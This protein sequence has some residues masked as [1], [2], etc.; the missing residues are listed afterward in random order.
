VAADAPPPSVVPRGISERNVPQFELVTTI[1]SAPSRVPDSRARSGSVHLACRL[2]VA[3]GLAYEKG[4]AM[5]V[6]T[7]SLTA[8][9]LGSGIGLIALCSRLRAGERS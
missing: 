3:L 7:L 1:G 6:I 2:Q 8:V 9:L 4:P 5:D